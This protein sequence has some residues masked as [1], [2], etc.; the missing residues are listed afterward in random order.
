MLLLSEPVRPG[1]PF[2]TGEEIAMLIEEVERE[3]QERQEKLA[4][5]V[6]LPKERDFHDR[7][8]D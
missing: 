1:E 3:E 8:K 7:R 5:S 2:L 6:N 4:S